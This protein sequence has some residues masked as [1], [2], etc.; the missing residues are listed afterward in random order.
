MILSNARIEKNKNITFYEQDII[1]DNKVYNDNI[2]VEITFDYISPGIGIALIENEGL[3]LSEYSTSYLFK[4]GFNKYEIIRNIANKQSILEAGVLLNCNPYQ[5]NVKL[6]VKKINDKIFIFFNDKLLVQRYLPNN[7]YNFNIGYYSTAGNIIKN[8][9]IS[10]DTPTGWNINMNNTNGGY[11]DFDYNSFT[12]KECMDI[13]EIE[14]ANIFLKANTISNKCYYLKYNKELVNGLNDIKAYVSLADD[15]RYDDDKKNILSNNKFI[16]KEDSYVNLKF[17]GTVGT[18]N[19]IQITNKKD[20]SYISTEYAKEE[21]KESYIE[22]LTNKLSKIEFK[23]YINSVP[24]R[25]IIFED[26]NYAIIKD[27]STSYSVENLNLEVGNNKLYTFIINLEGKNTLTI[28]NDNVLINASIL[29]IYNKITIFKNIDAAIVDLV[30]Y[31]KNGETIDAIN[32]NTRKEYVYGNINSPIIITD[33][34]GIPLNLSSSYRYYNNSYIF[35]NREREIFEVNNKIKLSN[36]ISDS[37]DSIVVYCIKKEADI[38][39]D[40]ILYLD[41][42]GMDNINQYATLYDTFYES[43][44]YSVNKNN[45]TIAIKDPNKEDMAS[46]YKA[47]IVDYLKKDSYAINYKYDASMYEVDISSSKNLYM[48]YDGIDKNLNNINNLSN[49]KILDIDIENSKYI[50][51]KGR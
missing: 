47:I 40:K 11:I 29:D 7:I 28:M 17:K 3:S 27:N 12:I 5:E 22:I 51:L 9:L 25:N 35:T 1:I 23:G 32:Q 13:A 43:N 15:D 38:N 10:A 36:D 48:Y 45:N 44:L 33:E 30:L 46:S 4:L 50:V 16:L 6:K 18:I 34:E 31:K 14:Q 19:N 41:E 42:N 49:N 8:I 24:E 39:E 2:E 21:T 26:V 20:D 37:L